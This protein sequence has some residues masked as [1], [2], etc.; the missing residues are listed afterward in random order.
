MHLFYCNFPVSLRTLPVSAVIIIRRCFSH[1]LQLADADSPSHVI[2][3]EMARTTVK[4]AVPYELWRWPLIPALA[5]SQLPGLAIGPA[6]NGY[7]FQEM[8]AC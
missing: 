2:V 5:Y 1:V 8:L 4:D 7:L 3:I 6:E